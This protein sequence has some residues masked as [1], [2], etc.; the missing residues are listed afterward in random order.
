MIYARVV[1]AAVVGCLLGVASAQGGQC[2]V[3]YECN[4]AYSDYGITYKYDFDGLCHDTDYEVTH[5]GTGQTFKFNICGTASFEC[6]PRWSNVYQY[7]VAVQY[8]GDA[9]DANCTDPHTGAEKPCTPDCQVLGVGQPLI[10]ILNPDLPDSGVIIK[11]VGVPPSA[12]DPYECPFDPKTGAQKPRSISYHLSCDESV[13]AL[14]LAN[15]VVNETSQCQYDI[16]ADTAAACAC[17]PQCLGKSCGPDGCGGY[18]SQYGECPVG[19]KCLD[20]Q[21]CCQPQCDRLRRDC[22]DDGCGGVCGSCPRGM[23]CDEQPGVCIGEDE[24]VKNNEHRYGGGSVA[25]A[26]FGGLLSCIVIGGAFVFAD[27]AGLLSGV[28]F[29]SRRGA[30]AAASSTPIGTGA[31][32]GAA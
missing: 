10:D 5:P 15:I 30:G 4:F 24:I 1:L 16:Y 20:D 7:G 9:P 2:D 19:M 32:Y 29:L 23:Y 26:F 28:S 25:G 22:G 14:E 8:F 12:D 17:N 13:P 18:C 27:R 21:T 3:D 31:G 11:H 6:L